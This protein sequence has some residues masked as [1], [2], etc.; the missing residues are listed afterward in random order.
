MK[1]FLAVSLLLFALSTA[2][3]QVSTGSLGGSITD[4]N[5]AIVPGASISVK[6]EATGVER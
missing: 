6:N 1:N 5:N 3:A 2:Q 4:P